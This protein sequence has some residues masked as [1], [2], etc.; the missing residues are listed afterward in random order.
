M[1]TFL[2]G[3]RGSSPP[4]MMRRP[5]RRDSDW[6]STI[7]STLSSLSTLS[8]VLLAAAILTFLAVS[9]NWSFWVYFTRPIWDPPVHQEMLPFFGFNDK[10]I[11]G[12]CALHGFKPRQKPVRIFDSMIFWNELDMLEVRLNELAGGPHTWP[13]G[14]SLS[15]RCPQ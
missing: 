5:P 6:V 12:S 2:R 3:L 14:V 13:P 9:L 4:L 10:D 15:I 1:S 11:P 8:K 7:I